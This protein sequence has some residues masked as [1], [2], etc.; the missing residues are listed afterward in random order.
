[1]LR[2]TKYAHLNYCSIIS[3]KR[4][5]HMVTH[6]TSC[7][8][9]ALHCKTERATHQHEGEAVY[10]YSCQLEKERKEERWDIRG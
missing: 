6:H 5:V 9:E 2:S 10:C 1:M 4:T 8:C 7:E 3:I